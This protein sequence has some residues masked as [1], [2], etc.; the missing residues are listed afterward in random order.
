MW[1]GSQMIP[2]ANAP[3]IKISLPL[4]NYSAPSCLP[5]SATCECEYESERVNVS[6][7]RLIVYL[8]IYCAY[9]NTVNQTWDTDGVSEASQTRGYTVSFMLSFFFCLYF[10]LPFISSLHLL[11]LRRYARVVI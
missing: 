4:L 1:N 5:G 10:L 6:E 11:I 8:D 7:F 2:V 9:W 3:A